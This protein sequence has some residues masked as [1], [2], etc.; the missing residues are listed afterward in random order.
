MIPSTIRTGTAEPEDDLRAKAIDNTTRQ[1]MSTCVAM[2]SKAGETAG[3]YAA[4]AGRGVATVEDVIIGLQY[5]AKVF[6]SRVTDEDV[7]EARKDV[8]AAMDAESSSEDSEAESEDSEAEEDSKEEVPWT[9]SH[10]DCAVCVGANE[11]QQTWDEW[12]PED[13][14]L[15]FL[16]RTTD[17]YIAQYQKQA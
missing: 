1:L 14:V 4:H 16:K 3:V 15:A 10:C 5:Q 11:A 13:E 7:A 2:V 17:K 12:D 6:M 9:R 8:D